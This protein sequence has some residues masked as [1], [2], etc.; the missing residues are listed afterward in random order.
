MAR[1][2]VKAAVAYTFTV[3][4]RPA[5]RP[6]PKERHTALVAAVLATA[7]D[8]SSIDITIPAGADGR[9]FM[10]LLTQA[11]RKGAKRET[12]PVKIR[13]ILEGSTIHLWA[14]SSE[15]VPA[16]PAVTPT[17]A[18]P[19]TTPAAGASEVEM[20]ITA[21]LRLNPAGLMAEELA[22]AIFGKA[23]GATA[24]ANQRVVQGALGTLSRKGVLLVD[25]AMRYT[26]AR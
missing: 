20:K 8:G 21:A 16:A 3:G 26:L 17:P 2:G 19:A 6:H 15:S 11:V 14:V 24:G 5:A 23:V 22:R 4:A 18:A 12:L 7:K 25:S 9:K 1:G 13:S 10:S